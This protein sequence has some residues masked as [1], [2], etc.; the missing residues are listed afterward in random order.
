MIVTKKKNETSNLGLI[1]TDL[2]AETSSGTAGALL[3]FHGECVNCVRQI[4][5]WQ[6]RNEN[7]YHYLGDYPIGFIACWL[8]VVLS[9]Q[10]ERET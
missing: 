2:S 1:N 9:R 4:G 8:G 10:K 7:L 5:I 6:V 3:L